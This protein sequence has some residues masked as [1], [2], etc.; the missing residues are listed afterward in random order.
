MTGADL[1]NLALVLSN[2][3]KDMLERA[4]VIT[5]GAKGG[6]DWKRFNQDILTFLIKL[7]ESRREILARL[8]EESLQ[9]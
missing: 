3:D 7:P 2:I 6:S 8:I 1:L 9:S 4:G 5:P